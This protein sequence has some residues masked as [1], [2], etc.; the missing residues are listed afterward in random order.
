MKLLN[1]SSLTTRLTLFYLTSTLLI[2]LCTTFFQFLALTEDL[3]LED[4]EFLSER[5][6]SI[7][8]IIA[9]HGDSLSDLNDNLHLDHATQSIRYLVR[10]QDKNGQIMMESH[11][12]DLIPPD[13]FPPPTAIGK[14]VGMGIRH[15]GGDGKHYLLNAAW[16]AGGGDDT[17]MRIQVALDVTED[18]DLIANYRLK[19]GISL[20]VGLCLATL[21][22]FTM[23]RKGLKPLMQVTEKVERIT[24]TDL[25]QRTRTEDWPK[26]L[27]QLT[28]AL[29]GMLARLENSFDR[30][31]EFSANLAHEL[32][33]P[34]NN[35]RGEAEVILSRP[36]S[37]EEYRQ[38]IESG[39]EE[40]ERLSRMVSEIL[41]LARPDKEIELQEIDARAELEILAEYYC[42]LGEEKNI[43]LGIHG[44]GTLQ[45]DPVLFQ[46][47]VG[48]VISNAIQYSPNDSQ[49]LIHIDTVRDDILSIAIRDNG[50]G[51]PPEEQERVF[52]RFYRSTYAREYH[53]HGSGLGLAIVKSIMDLHDGAVHLESESG[54]G[55]TVTLLF[56][57]Y[58]PEMTT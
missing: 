31:Q 56:P 22:G 34:L 45:A 26:E 25:N 36:R 23:T 37:A 17:L 57:R 13:V 43:T 46:R 32:R 41:F 38:T 24:S 49:I 20:V 3:A 4:N 28:V 29:D 54:K 44:K 9:S 51:I 5:I 14:E 55:T 40:Y 6:A 18:I 39:M 16:A 1:K 7:R 19:M 11:G 53:H 30:L 50:I 47:A 15:A 10:L 8:S 2:L 12:I 42:T 27:D 58:H 52:Q 48:N 35:L 33:T 21:F